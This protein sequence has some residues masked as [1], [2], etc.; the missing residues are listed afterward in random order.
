MQ[1]IL[2]AVLLAGSVNPDEPWE[3]LLGQ[4]A[5]A[6]TLM[7]QPVE[8]SLTFERTLGGRFVR[9]T[10][11]ARTSEGQAIFGGE[12]LYR[13]CEPTDF[14]G[15]WADTAG[16]LYVV[17]GE[18]AGATLNTAWGDPDVETGRSSY[19]LLESGELRVTDQVLRAEGWATFAT[20]EYGRVDR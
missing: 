14:S 20:I 15:R 1:T 10:Y 12:G 17:S 7:S 4:W 13:C 6:G 11:E 3:S 18:F 19:E 5:G 2:A 16:H 9:L 8:A